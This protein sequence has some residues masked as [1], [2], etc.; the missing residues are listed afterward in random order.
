MLNFSREVNFLGLDTE[1]LENMARA[2][3][4]KMMQAAIGRLVM[5]SVPTSED[6]THSFPKVRI[7]AHYKANER[8]NPPI[9]EVE[10][11]A[12]YLDANDKQGFFICAHWHYNTREFSF[13]S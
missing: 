5:W 13:N 11:F 3:D 8:Y 10:F 6:G 7:R 9:P 1:I 12:S 2:S 4:F